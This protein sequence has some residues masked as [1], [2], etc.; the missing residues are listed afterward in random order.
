M[1]WRE[2]GDWEVL[3]VE[4][5]AALNMG[6][7]LG[8]I[9]SEQPFQFPMRQINLGLKSLSLL[10]RIIELRQGSGLPK[11]PLRHISVDEILKINIRK[12]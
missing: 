5:T 10:R 6:L 8:S 11:L 12:G 4:E 9:D 1:G 7:K 3:F 2:H